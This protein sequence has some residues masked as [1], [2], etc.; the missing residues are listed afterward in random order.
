MRNVS[1]NEN[2]LIMGSEEFPISALLGTDAKGLS[3]EADITENPRSGSTE[4]WRI[5]NTTEDTHPIH[6]H[7]VQFQMLDRIPFDVDAF[8]ADR[9]T[10]GPI[11]NYYTGAPIP[12]SP[13]EAERKDTVRANPG[14][15]TRIIAK[16]DLP[17]YVR[18]PAQ[19]V[20]HCHILE[21]EDNEMMRPYSV[22]QG[23]SFLSRR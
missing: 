3:W 1:L 4:I 12:P 6:L 20:W 21:H 11:E 18:P 19:Y 14:E 2:L 15:V 17:S 22:E 5:I 7:L 9:P 16:F 13:N 23:S 8:L 10:P